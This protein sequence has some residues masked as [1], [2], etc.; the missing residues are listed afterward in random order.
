MKYFFVVIVP[1]FRFYVF[2]TSNFATY[3]GRVFLF[4]FHPCSLLFTTFSLVLIMDELCNKSYK[5]QLLNKLG[6]N[7]FFYMIDLIFFPYLKNFLVLVV[8]KVFK[9]IRFLPHFCKFGEW[10]RCVINMSDVY[11][12]SL[13]N[14]DIFTQ[15]S[16][17]SFAK[18]LVLSIANAFRN[19]RFFPHFY[20]CLLE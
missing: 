6:N 18:K 8:I 7:L 1:S 17:L 20:Y 19:I 3:I 14:I 10:L 5:Y 9:N 16:R 15:E 11:H 13:P 12:L 4:E 2:V